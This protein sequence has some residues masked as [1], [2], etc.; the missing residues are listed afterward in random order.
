MKKITNIITFADPDDAK[1]VALAMLGQ[2]NKSILRRTRGLTDGKV[3]Y[4]LSKHQRI[5]DKHGGYRVGWRNGESDLVK[6]VLSDIAGVVQQEI[7]R[8]TPGRIE[9]RTPETTK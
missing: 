4:R 5:E 6:Q 9:H 8:S 1:A 2:S 7:Q 3:T